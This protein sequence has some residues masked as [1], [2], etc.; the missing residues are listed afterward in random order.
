M[1]ATPKVGRPKLAK[2]ERRS[3]FV[4]TRLSPEEYKEIED[5]IKESGIDKTEWIRRKL[6]AAARRA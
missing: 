6:L 3:C 5:A 2:A 4:S 1:S